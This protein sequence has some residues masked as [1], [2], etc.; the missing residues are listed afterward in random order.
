LG[1]V[2]LNEA[3]N[4][5][6]PLVDAIRKEGGLPP[7]EQAIKAGRLILEYETLFGSQWISA[8]GMLWH[9]DGPSGKVSPISL[10]SPDF[11]NIL[12]YRYGVFRTEPFTRHIVAQIEAWASVRAVKRP[13]RRF[14]CYEDGKLYVTGFDGTAWKLDGNAVVQVP[15]G[16]GA[17][18]MEEGGEPCP[19][20]VGH[21]GLLFSALVGDLQWSTETDSGMGP[22]LQA[23]TFLSW[24]LACGFH[25]RFPSKPLLLVEGVERSGKSYAL[26]RVQYVLTGKNRAM[27]IGERGQDQFPI[28]LLHAAPIAILDNQDTPI[29]WL[30]DE[31][32]AYTTNGGWPRRRLYTDTDDLYIRP[33]SFI[34]VTSRDP[35]TFRRPDIA[36]R[37]FLIRLEQR[38][39]T[40]GEYDM[41]VKL[42]AMRGKLFGEWLWYCN[43]VVRYLH[44]PLPA[45]FAYRLADMAQFI[46]AAVRAFSATTEQA[47]QIAD[48]ILSAAQRERDA[49]V[50]EEEP[51][52]EIVRGWVQENP[53]RQLTM[54]ELYQELGGRVAGLLK[55]PTTVQGFTRFWRRVE[56]IVT[57]GMQIERTWHRGIRRVKFSLANAKNSP[58]ANDASGVSAVTGLESLD[59]FGDGRKSAIRDNGA[60]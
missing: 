1:K 28:N 50:L 39:T 13:L 42:A 20:E 53:D 18:F 38:P 23:A 5:A 52:A 51:L 6:L 12:A 47:A 54:M 59:L 25:D 2:T 43:E 49:L 27:I 34:A 26:K 44:E 11:G 24:I 35:K 56:P 45:S 37:C 10:R 46:H 31:V 60:N 15:N 41:Q 30:K 17:L 7:H 29:E 9:F 4:L 55:W 21:H 58:D 48:A 36:D 22:D 3:S 19:V 16:D 14:S 57:R 40:S 8:D 33:E 32:A